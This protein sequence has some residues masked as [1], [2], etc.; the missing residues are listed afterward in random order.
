M[1]VK[2]THPNRLDAAEYGRAIPKG[3]GINLLV[4]DMTA[5]ANFQHDVLGVH[6]AYED[7]DFAIC[8]GY[9]SEWM[10]HADHTYLDHPMTGLVQNVEA[11]GIGVEIRL[12]GCDPDAAEAR[13]RSVDA[14]VLHGAMDKP[15]GLREC[16]LVDPEGYVWVPCVPLDE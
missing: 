12:Y 2:S 15:H 1:A 11:R 9:G 13:A 6:L 16:F 5:A 10:L 4:R 14:I 8:R 7:E 3:L